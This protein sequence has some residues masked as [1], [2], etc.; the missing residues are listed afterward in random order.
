MTIDEAKITELSQAFAPCDPAGLAAEIWRLD[1]EIGQLSTL[2]RERDRLEE[3]LLHLLLTKGGG[4]VIV[5]DHPPL[6]LVHGWEY[7][8]TKQ[9]GRRVPKLEFDKGERKKR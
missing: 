6:R 3:I 1:V 9:I 2:R 5:G 8:Y 4:E 7:D